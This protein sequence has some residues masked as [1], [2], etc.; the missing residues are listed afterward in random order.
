MHGISEVRSTLSI[1]EALLI[2]DESGREKWLPPDGKD[3]DHGALLVLHW[4]LSG[5]GP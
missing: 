3:T 4:K 1:L 2:K 5:L